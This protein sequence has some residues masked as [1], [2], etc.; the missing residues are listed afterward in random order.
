M[1]F[2]CDIWVF[3]NIFN[4]TRNL[5][6]FVLFSFVQTFHMI[7]A[8]EE[9]FPSTVNKRQ[10]QQKQHII[11]TLFWVHWEE[12]IFNFQIMLFSY[13]KTFRNDCNALYNTLNFSVS[14]ESIEYTNKLYV[15][16]QFVYYSVK[17]L[18]RKVVWKHTHS[19]ER[20]NKTL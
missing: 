1:W 5:F 15:N 13:T 19:E 6:V 9:C 7:Y 17:L 20:E 10:H 11:R 3:P 4:H 2:Q 18:H 14:I 12:I 8:Y 16:T